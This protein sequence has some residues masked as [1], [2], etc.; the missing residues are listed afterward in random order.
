MN[1][2]QIKISFY[3][4]D[5]QPE[6]EIVYSIVAGYY[7]GKWIFVRHRGNDTWEM[8]AGHVEKGET[9]A[10]AAARELAEETGAAV[11]ELH[12]V[13]TYSVETDSN[14][15]FGKLYFAD[16]KKMED[17]TDKDEI[18]EVTFF[19]GIPSEL[20][21]PYIQPVLFSRVFKYI[22]KLSS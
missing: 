22:Q 17:F 11:F 15:Q 7:L 19:S 9:P 12:C 16:I 14:T 3:N 5:Y 1:R 2:K 20:T 13:A 6:S 8:P 21:Y 18:E 4:P 10:Q